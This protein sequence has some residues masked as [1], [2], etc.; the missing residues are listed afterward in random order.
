MR[1]IPAGEAYIVLV[2]LE[3]GSGEKI[4]PTGITYTVVDDEGRV[5]LDPVF[6][7]EIPENE[8]AIEIPAAAN[9][10]PAGLAMA[11]RTLEIEFDTARGTVRK[12]ETWLVRAA[13]QLQ[14]LKNSFQSLAGAELTAAQMVK[15]DAFA[16]ATKETKQSALLEAYQRLTRLGYFVRE[17]AEEEG[18]RDRIVGCSWRVTPREFPVMTEERWAEFPDRFKKALRRAQVV[19]ANAILMPGQPSDF[20]RQGLLSRTVG[21]SSAMF[22]SGAPLDLGIAR[23]TLDQLNGYVELRM[24]TTRA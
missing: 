10:L 5:V 4:S 23:E 20:R 7:S 22:R 17:D 3:N 19:E 8:I 14:P 18:W 13:L 12:D 9:T 1:N 24:V 15:L 16:R 11:A 21:E 6:V 2:P